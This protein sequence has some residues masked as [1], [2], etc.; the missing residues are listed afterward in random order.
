MSRRNQRITTSL[1]TQIKAKINHAKIV[2]F[3]LCLYGATNAFQLYD[4]IGETLYPN[5]YLYWGIGNS[6][7]LTIPFFVC[8]F[9][10]K[11]G[12]IFGILLAIF[13]ILSQE[14]YLGSLIWAYVIVAQL[15]A[16]KAVLDSEKIKTTSHLDDNILD[17]DL[18]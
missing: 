3:F 15:L 13:L 14:F 9:F 1:K 18:F 4:A 16:Y 7:I 10:R 17:N 5:E 6:I 11:T 8:L 12:F 2:L